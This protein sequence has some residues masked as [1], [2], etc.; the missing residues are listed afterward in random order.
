MEFI[1]VATKEEFITEI[2]KEF[3]N[4]NTVARER[5]FSLMIAEGDEDPAAI[6]R[7]SVQAARSDGSI[8]LLYDAVVLSMLKLLSEP[9]KFNSFEN[10]SEIVASI[11]EEIFSVIPR[12]RFPAKLLA[13]VDSIPDWFIATSILIDLL[14]NSISLNYAG[15]KHCSPREIAIAYALLRGPDWAHPNAGPSDSNIIPFPTSAVKH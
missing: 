14:I 4:L 9:D 13:V 8:A 15:L 5:L 3:F 1:T 10:Q 7:M 12:E 11:R 2:A 6:A